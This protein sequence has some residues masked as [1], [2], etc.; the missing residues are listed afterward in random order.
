MRESLLT[1]LACP[2]CSGDLALADPQIAGG[3][4]A[5]GALACRG[6]GRRFPIEHGV[7][8]FVAA[9]ERKDVIQTCSGFARNWDQFNDVILDNEELN[10]ELFRDWIAPVDP[11][12]FRGKLLLEPGCGM[13]RWLCV[14]ARY[15][16][17]ALIGV[18]YSTVAYTAA[19]NVSHLEN[20]HV[21]R[22]DILRLPLKKRIEM[23]YCLGVVHHTPDP[24]RTFDT[25][26]ETLGP[27]GVLTVWVYGAENNGWI[28]RLITPLRRHV[29]SK[30]P[31]RLLGVLSILLALPLY[32][33][34]AAAK[35]MR[36]PYCEYLRYLRRY[37]FRY[38]SHIV[39][40]HL[41][42]E[43]A[44]YLPRAEL[45]RWVAK[46]GLHAQLSSR[47]G[48]S[49]RLLTSRLAEA[50]PAALPKTGS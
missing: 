28:T 41:V 32:G 45:D 29:T 22:A 16:P 27:D 6:C 17:R 20:V 1:E 44:H 2:D 40:D 31:H 25:L 39:Y 30:L 10:D 5:S 8:N 11:E 13:G 47:N 43:I 38:M 23:I 21:V 7:P 14:A 50:L 46:H 42:P 12:S 3:Q 19:H 33:L 37:P 35:R 24:A 49:W 34:A 18:D 48:N 26:V 4:I 9:G 36:L 15:G